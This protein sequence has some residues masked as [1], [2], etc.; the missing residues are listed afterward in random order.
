M[1]FGAILPASF[2][3]NFSFEV[4]DP[5]TPGVVSKLTISYPCVML[6]ADVHATFTNHQYQ[7]LKS[8]TTMAY[9]TKSECSILKSMDRTGMV[10]PASHEEGK[11]LKKR[12]AVFNHDGSLAELKGFEMKRRAEDNQNV[13]E[14]GV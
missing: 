8:E 11:L 1:A 13:P 7:D 4:E 5:D 6:N 3:E 12:Y 9:S 2:P 10:I 14:A